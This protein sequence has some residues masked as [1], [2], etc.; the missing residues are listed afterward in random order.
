MREFYFD[1]LFYTYNFMNTINLADKLTL[2]KDY[3]SP[4]IVGELTGQQVKLAKFNG[5]FVWHHHENEDEMFLVLDGNL[6]IEFRDKILSA[7]PGEFIIVPRGVEH[8]PV[9]EEE[10]SVLLFEPAST[11]NTGEVVNERTVTDLDR[12]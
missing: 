11:L 5:E 9:A 4:K 1:L 10:V 2:I 6:E 12:I 7:G 8:K 3:W